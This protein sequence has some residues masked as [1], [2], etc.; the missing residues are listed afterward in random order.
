MKLR[1]SID[2]FE[3]ERKRTAVLLTDRGIQIDFPKALLPKGSRAGDVLTV[4]IE[5]DAEATD[6]LADEA[7]NLQERLSQNDPGG[8]IRL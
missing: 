3:G 2:R 7:R 8:D 5:K 4:I 6:Q 1:L